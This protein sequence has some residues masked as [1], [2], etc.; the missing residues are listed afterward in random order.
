[1]VVVGWVGWFGLNECLGE[2]EV[3]DGGVGETSDD[4]D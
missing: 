2:V 4:D 1:M 3:V